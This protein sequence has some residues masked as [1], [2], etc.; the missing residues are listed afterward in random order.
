MAVHRAGSTD[1]QLLHRTELGHV[2]LT[3]DDLAALM[4]L[5]A[6]QDECRPVVEFDGGYFTEAEDLRTLSDAELGSLRVRTPTVQV[7]L[8]S[9]SASAIGEPQEAE[10]VYRSWARVRQTSDKPPSLR[11]RE[12]RIYSASLAAA[13]GAAMSL[14]ILGFIVS[15]FYV[16]PIGYILLFY[17]AF[18]AMLEVG[19][20]GYLWYGARLRGSGSFTVVEPMSLAEYRQRRSTEK[21]PRRSWI[22]SVIAVIATAV[23]SVVVFIL[24]KVLSP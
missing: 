17:V 12:N 21:Y 24:S 5:L 14:C 2:I 3:I 16:G 23:V 6:T 22:V 4:T 13:L 7:V 10:N 19:I 20:C 8:Y 1:V 11:S 9:S 18:V 15:Q